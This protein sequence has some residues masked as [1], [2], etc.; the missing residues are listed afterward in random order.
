MPSH[1]WEIEIWTRRNDGELPWPQC[2]VIVQPISGGPREFENLLFLM[3]ASPRP[4]VFSVVIVDR[5]PAD[6]RRLAKIVATAERW[7]VGSCHARAESA[8]LKLGAQSPMI[9]L[10]DIDLPGSGGIELMRR[11]RGISPETRILIVSAIRDRAWVRAAFAAGASGYLLKTVS[12]AELLGAMDEVVAGGVPMSREIGCTVVNFLRSE[13][14]VAEKPRVESGFAKGQ[15][16][17]Q[18]LPPRL[19]QREAEALELLAQGLL[20]KEIAISLGIQMETV[21]FHLGNLYRKLGV[22]TRTEAAVKFLHHHPA[23]A[24]RSK[25]RYRK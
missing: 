19:T 8:L 17:G 2:A 21:S 11:A 6:R 4:P 12:A 14:E 1:A 24:P 18:R 13:C 25:P 20:Y 22:R 3:I 7:S 5:N 16:A 9:C 23:T 15:I 10:L